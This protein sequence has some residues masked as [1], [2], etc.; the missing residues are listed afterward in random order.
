MKQ[1]LPFTEESF[2]RAM[3]N[4]KIASKTLS[5]PGHLVTE[6]DCENMN[7]AVEG[8]IDVAYSLE[9]RFSRQFKYNQK[10]RRECP[11][12][13]CGNKYAYFYEDFLFCPRCGTKLVTTRD[14]RDKERLIGDWIGGELGEC[15]VCHHKG[16]SSDI[17]NNCRNGCFCPN[18]GA[19][20]NK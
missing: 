3:S 15:G 14:E 9:R 8:A 2:F 16:R 11:N 4:L 18:C 13:K 12:E 17:W 6:K 5:S 1:Q 10:V 20:M 19:E 7:E